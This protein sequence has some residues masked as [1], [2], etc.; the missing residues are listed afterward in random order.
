[1]NY[2][3]QRMPKIPLPRAELP[4]SSP[5]SSSSRAMPIPDDMK[6][7]GFEDEYE[8]QPEQQSDP[9]RIAPDTNTNRD[10]YP[11]G[12]KDLINPSLGGMG[13]GQTGSGGIYGGMHPTLND[14]LFRQFGEEGGAGGSRGSRYPSG[15]IPGA[16]WD[17][18]LGGGA[19]GPGGFGSG[20]AGGY[21]G[22]RGGGGFSGGYI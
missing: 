3:R 19:T 18:P 11:G 5:P 13:L 21:G 8:L 22:F 14:P 16:R 9:L 10:L 7:P 4:I 17:D 1:M 20:G 2:P 12:V 15:R 6:P